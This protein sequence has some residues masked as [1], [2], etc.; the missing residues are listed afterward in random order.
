MFKFKLEN[1]ERKEGYNN[2]MYAQAI[3]DFTL[4]KKDRASDS[5]KF[6]EGSDIPEL[7]V[8]VKAERFTLALNVNGETV[9]EQVTDYLNRVHSTGWIYVSKNGYGYGMNKAEFTEFLKIGCRSSLTDTS[10]RHNQPIQKVVRGSE[11]S[12]TGKISKFFAS[13]NPAEITI[14]EAIA[15]FKSF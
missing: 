2:G 6:D 5:V 1:C 8:S 9:A 12:A 4:M 14:A 10:G 15:I 3:A 7:N 13:Y 11:E